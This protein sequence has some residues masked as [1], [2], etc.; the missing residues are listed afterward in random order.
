MQK[1]IEKAADILINRKWFLLTAIILI[2]AS[3]S[4]FLKNLNIDN[5]LE[6]WFLKDDVNLINY[7]EF[8]DR[9]G[10]DEVII[11][12]IK[13][14]NNIYDKDFIA[15]IYET[16]HT[17]KQHELIKR[18]ISIT[19]APFI[20]GKG[21]E[22]I[23]EDMLKNSPDKN[24]SG[25]NLKQRLS[26][27][28]LWDKLLLNKDRSAV[29]MLI[30]PVAT[31]NMD[32][33][34]PILLKF[35][36]DSLK[37]FDT[38][39]AGMGV[40]YEEL[41]RIS[42][43]DSGIFTVVSY[44]ILMIALFIIFRNTGILIAANFTII[45]STVIF[46]GIY[47]ISGQK[48]TMVSVILPTLILILCLADTIHVFTHYAKTE[49]GKDRLKRNL[50]FVLV[51]CLFTTLTTAVGFLALV[52]SPMQVLK[53]FGIFASIGVSISYFIA[54]IISSLVLSRSEE[55]AAKNS[56]LSSSDLEIKEDYIDRL[57]KKISG[58]SIANY[59][60]I[61]VIGVVLIFI[62]IIGIT[63]LSVD[64]FSI[65]FLADDNKVRNDS[66]FFENDYGFYLPL[67]IR[68][69][70]KEGDVKEPVFLKKLD[71]MQKALDSH[72]SFER[73]TS[74][75]DVVKQLNRV[76]TDNKDTSYKIPESRNAV[77]QELLLYEMSEDNDLNVFVA[78]D[79]SEVRVTTRIPMVSSRNMQNI[80]KESDKII[81][82][83]FK[84]S[85]EVI[86]GGYIPLYVKMMDYVTR[87]Q[88]T[89][90]LIAISFIFII[91]GILFK[92]FSSVLIGLAP[93]VLPIFLTLGFMGW[94]GINLDIATV[95]I[96]AIAIGISVDDTIHFLFVYNKKRSEGDTISQAIE[97]TLTTSGK[98]IITTSFL[99]VL[100]YSVF[101][102]AG[103]KSIIYFGLLIS[104]TMITAV[105]SDLF[106][107]PSLLMLFSKKEDR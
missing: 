88:I 32:A 92:S 53:G 22:L 78:D 18:V 107:L 51:P 65:D 4:L 71:E 103:I 77:A 85:A 23:V 89:S 24:Y 61:S 14:E 36:S 69:K 42:M 96:A 3:T 10:N 84:G 58:I 2:T 8:K 62:S 76:L 60:I 95:T 29:I 57:L 80:M 56:R 106:L 72:P 43:R 68:M 83:V 31:G 98:A 38:R 37:Q 70:P 9:Y 16:S 11:V 41:N 1:F 12:K 82:T 102:F 13:P 101:A 40:V 47:A 86:Y 90:F 21:G 94:V 33:N 20:D 27:N 48:F 34:R 97:H 39:L 75:A 79:Y 6:V 44:L 28:P 5:S 59:K 64:T 73:T 87:S 30:E 7:N 19:N 15:K 17:I 26:S 105:L 46:L 93:N 54:M 81:N 55:K 25:E 104:V 74:L 100:G 50:Q 45:F 52:S 91:I 99:L 63:R 66:H 67:E 49:P 35:V